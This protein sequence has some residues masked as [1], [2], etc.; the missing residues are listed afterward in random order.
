MSEHFVQFRVEGQTVYG[1]LHLPD[2]E[3]KVPAVALCH[4]FTGNRIEAHRLFVKMARCL[5]TNGI[6]ALRF[7]FRGCGESE[8]DFEQVT[9]SSEITDALAALDFLRKQ[10]EI[11][12]ERIGLIGLSLGGCVATCAAARDGRVRALVLWAAV[13]TLRDLFEGRMDSTTRDLLT[14]QGWLDFGGWKVTKAF[15]EDAAQ[16]DPLREALRYDG[17][18]LIVHGGNDPVVPVDHAHRYHSAFQYTKRL[19]IIPDADHTFARLTWEE[20]VMQVTLEWL[21]THL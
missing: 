2:R 4:G 11:D 13:A 5:A 9:V 16:I 19:H 17:A 10:P 8:G 15:Y 12:P 18:V 7:D 1:M 14:K 20:E 3:G 6:A 21:Q